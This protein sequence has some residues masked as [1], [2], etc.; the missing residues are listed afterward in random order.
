MDLLWYVHH[1]KTTSLKATTIPACYSASLYMLKSVWPFK[2]CKTCQLKYKHI[3]KHLNCHILRFDSLG[4]IY[5]FYNRIL[6]SECTSFIL[7]YF[8]S[9]TFLIITRSKLFCNLSEL[10]HTFHSLTDK[11]YFSHQQVSLAARCNFTCS[12]IYSAVGNGWERRFWL[13]PM[14]NMFDY[15][16]PVRGNQG[17]GR[18]LFPGLTGKLYC[19]FKQMPHTVRCNF[20]CSMI[21][22]VVGNGWDRKLW[23]TLIFLAKAI[24]EDP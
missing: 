14:I 7:I 18:I 5:R 2:R 10:R 20:P 21:Y 22:S 16:T 13:S 17:A 23:M 11:L 4:H 8:S 19:F 3:L 12:M 9:L 1:F 24:V 15:R 6:F